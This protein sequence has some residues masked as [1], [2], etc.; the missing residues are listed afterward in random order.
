[1]TSQSD[2]LRT[3]A[4]EL[5]RLRG[6]SPQAGED[7]ARWY[8][9][10]RALVGRLEDEFADVDVPEQVWHYLHDADLRVKDPAFGRSQDGIIDSLIASFEQGVIPEVPGVTIAIHPVWLVVVPVIGALL[11]LYGYAR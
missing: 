10:A 3:I 2:Q 4:S 5:R 6:L 11:V 7:D 8:I 9:E 1:M